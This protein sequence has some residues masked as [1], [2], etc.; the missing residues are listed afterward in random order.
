[1]LGI[2][3]LILGRQIFRRDSEVF[4]SPIDQKL[5]IC[6]AVVKFGFG[7]RRLAHRRGDVIYLSLLLRTSRCAG[8]VDGSIPDAT[9]KSA[10]APRHKATA[11]MVR[12]RACVRQGAARGNGQ[13]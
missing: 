11:V 2:G 7:K 5:K 1:M 9:A 4:A 3:Q 13:K 6:P 10:S 12:G 8:L